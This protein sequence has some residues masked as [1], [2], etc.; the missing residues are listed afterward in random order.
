VRN[1]QSRFADV[2]TAFE[3]VRRQPVITIMPMVLETPR[4]RALALVPA[5]RE[6]AGRHVEIQPFPRR[7]G[8]QFGLK[9]P[10]G[11]PDFG[12]RTLG[13]EPVGD[14]VEQVPEQ[15]GMVRMKEFSAVHVTAP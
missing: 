7:H 10:F 1:D 13:V 3:Q 14:M 15:A 12:L 5:Q 9:P 6:I 8:V 11:A 4:G 2:E